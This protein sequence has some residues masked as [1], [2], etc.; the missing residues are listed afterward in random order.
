M[1]QPPKSVQA[2]T[3]VRLAS[4]KNTLILEG[5]PDRRVYQIWVGKLAGS[6]SVALGK[7]DLVS[8]GGKNDV[9][10]T[11]AWFR[12]HGGNPGNLLGLVDRDEWAQTTISARMKELPQLRVVARRHALESYFCEPNEVRRALKAQTPAL[13]KA[14]L[15]AFVIQTRKALADRVNHWCLFTVT[16]RVKNRLGEAQFPGVFHDQY[17]LPSDREVKKRLK[18]WSSIVKVAAIFSEFDQLRSASSLLSE[19]EQFR[20]CVWAKPFYEQI[21]YG[22]AF[23]LQSLRNTSIHIPG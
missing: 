22:G 13:A 20:S 15:D 5:E 3:S 12:D 18:T 7:V 8:T 19:S 17:V 6:A 2:V 16:E 23:G 10:N 1:S 21:V 11:L 4:G 14:R 9:L